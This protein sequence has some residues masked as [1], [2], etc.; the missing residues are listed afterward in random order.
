MKV[1]STGINNG[2]IDDRFGCRGDANQWGIPSRSLPLKFEGAPEGTVSF[3]VVIEDKDAFPVSGGFAW[4]HWTAA[5]IKKNELAENESADAK[6]FVQGVNS[7]ISIQGGSK[8]VEACSCY[9]GMAPPE[10]HGTHIYEIW[11]YALD[12]VLELEN[13][14]HLNQLFRAMEGHVLEQAVLKA[15]YT[16]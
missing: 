9:G 11:V 12:A 6:D 7:W 4:I 5:N 15:E 16:N 1:T 13:G 10:G 3:A 8:P 2:V 14:F